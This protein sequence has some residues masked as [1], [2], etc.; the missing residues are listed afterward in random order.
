[1]DFNENRSETNHIKAQN[2][3]V[4]DTHK[5]PSRD[6]KPMIFGISAV[7]ILIAAGGLI[8]WLMSDAGKGAEDRMEQ[9]QNDQ[10]QLDSA[11]VQALELQQQLAMSE[12]ENA[13]R[14]LVQLEG[15]R[16]LVTSDN[17]KLRLTRQYEA[18][19]VE[20]ERLKKQ[21]D[22]QLKKQ[23]KADAESAAEISKLRGEIETLRGL[24]RHYLEEIARLNQ[25]NDALRAE[26]QQLS[27]D[28]QSTT[29]RA[30]DLDQ[31]NQV[32]NER[33]TLAEKLNVTGVGL[34]ALNKKGKNEKKVQKAAQ[35]VI[36]FT[37]PQ[38]NSTPVGT[39]TVYARLISPEGSLLGGAGSF[40]FEG[41]SVACSA[42]KS[43]DYE[44]AE[45]SLRIYVDVNTALSPGEYT[46]EL[47]ADNYRLCS[48][49]I[50]MK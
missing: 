43:F 11:A 34:T 39:K 8:W 32:L 1:M 10:N 30:N 12:L 13:D 26:N 41:A 36:S 40:S 2:N 9:A 6:R 33:M 25:E 44:G 3:R 20:I 29:A 46:V 37:I 14:D 49:R 15:Q 4:T 47:F 27:S 42:K 35:F 21:L 5:R 48:R 16:E 22:A 18:A 24:L 7:V 31:R 19:R 38:N 50:S 45:V 23:K 28:L 17:T